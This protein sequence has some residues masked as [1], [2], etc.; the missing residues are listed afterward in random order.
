[1]LG[2][3][4]EFLDNDGE[5]MREA[6]LLRESFFNPVVLK[7]TD[8]DPILKYL[9][10]DNAQEIDTKVVDD[11]RNFLFGAP[12]QGGFDL[13]A[14]NIQRGR[15]HG[16][17]DYN[18]V[19]AAYGLPP[20]TNFE[21]I[22]SDKALQSS[23]QSLYGN[24]DN[25][26]L[27]VGGL[28]EDHLSNSSLGSTFTAILI[29][30]FTRLRDGDRFWYEN[31]LSGD[32]LERIRTTTLADVIR[33]NT[34]IT[35]LQA[36]VF[37]F[38]ESTQMIDSASLSAPVPDPTPSNGGLAQSTAPGSERRNPPQAAFDACSSST[39]DSACSFVGRNGTT[40]N[41]TCRIPPDVSQIVCVPA[42][43][44]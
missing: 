12:G 8:I 6:M 36:D 23:L 35:K 4:I 34:K 14:L 3:D 5:E 38:N 33:R 10:S 42:R 24:V 1:M 27:W 31:S 7:T 39:M 15:D 20:V 26:D 21:Q 17:A 2:D 13:A 11:V 25:I 29:D 44:P 30:Q 32:M 19:R 40:V 18:S 41:G 22:T 9:A 28:A 37:F 16:L 43:R